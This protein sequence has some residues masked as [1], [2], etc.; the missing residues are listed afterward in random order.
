VSMTES[1]LPKL[2]AALAICTVEAAAQPV[3]PTVVL[4]NGYQATCDGGTSDSTATFGAMES[5]LIED[6]WQ[7]AFFDN[8]SVQ[9]GSTG[10]ARPTIEELAQAFGQFLNSLGSPRVDVV[11]H[12][13][14]GL[15]V[16]AWLAGKQP[17][18][19][20]SPPSTVPI[21]K[22]VFIATPNAGVLAAA[23]ILGYNET[24]S[25]VVEMF[26]GSSFLWDLAT[27]NQRTDDLQGIDALSLAGNNGGN[28]D[29]AH[30]SDGVVAVTSA[31]MAATLGTTRV[32]VLPY[33]HES[34][35]PSLLCTGPGIAMVTDR[36]HPT[37]QIVSSFLSGSTDWQTIGADAAQDP[38]LAQHAG[39]LIDFRDN[40]GNP[41]PNPGS[42]TLT[43]E[44]G[45]SGR[46]QQGVL[47]WNS[48]G[49]SFADYL[50]AGP[51]EA[52]LDSASYP[53]SVMGGGH[54]AL[55][56]KQGPSIELV[57]AAAA[58]LPTLNRAPGMLISIYGSNLQGASVTINGVPSPILFESGSQINTIIPAQLLG[59]AP[60]SVSSATGQDT[61]NIM[62]EPCVPAI[63]SADGSGTGAAL[64]LHG[65]G[66]PV[67]PSSPANPGEIISIF[68]TGLGVPLEAP[69]IEADGSPVTV[70]QVSPSDSPGVSI[71]QL[72]AP[73]PATGSSTID[74]QAVAGGFS[75][76]IVSLYVT[77]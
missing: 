77:P 74:I 23:G 61:L 47:P 15:I 76:N 36:N 60:L 13:M 56:L 45:N 18:G 28:G 66:S 49:V 68:L 39:A 70:T 71:L 30:T 59:L 24:D 57:N 29:D 54:I 43:S 51:Y 2:L 27:W 63:F 32:R 6:G 35:L 58:N 9:P 19:T 42:A 7:V 25:Q 3:Q 34:N 31:S 17:N 5:L 44:P 16:R 52:Q 55:E 21:Q 12:S 41:V 48:E 33:C 65:D 46:P 69:A 73:G 14:G 53:F 8:C 67:S 62:I 38:V 20:F 10:S 4:V 64:A 40:F 72:P 1:T 26:A 11:A 22:A 50:T 37:Y 75:S